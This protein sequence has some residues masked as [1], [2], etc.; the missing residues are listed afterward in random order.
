MKHGTKAH[1]SRC[2]VRDD[3]DDGSSDSADDTSDDEMI[4]SAVSDDDADD[5]K[6]GHHSGENNQPLSPKQAFPEEGG[7]TRTA[8]SLT[9]IKDRRGSLITKTKTAV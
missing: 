1:R 6:E 2:C 5:N 8:S 4:D 3:D 9:A 7:M